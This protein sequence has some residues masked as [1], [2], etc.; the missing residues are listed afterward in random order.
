MFFPV[1]SVVIPQIFVSY[2]KSKAEM[3]TKSSSTFVPTIW[4][5]FDTQFRIIRLILSRWGALKL[6]YP[7]K[8]KF[9]MI[10]TL[11]RRFQ[12]FYPENSSGQIIGH[13]IFFIDHPWVDNN[14]VLKNKVGPKRSKLRS[15]VKKIWY[16]IQNKI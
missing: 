14:F 1:F 4:L 7:L 3:G 10:R 13:L 2:G 6:P 8:L 12:F 15:K 16:F 9:C 11:I 5:Y